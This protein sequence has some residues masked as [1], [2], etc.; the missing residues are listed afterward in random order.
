MAASSQDYDLLFWVVCCSIFICCR[1]SQGRV[2]PG[3]RKKGCH[4]LIS[5]KEKSNI[6]KVRKISELQIRFEI[7]NY[8]KSD[9]LTSDLLEV[10]LGAGSKFIYIYTY[11]RV[12][13]VTWALVFLSSFFLCNW[14]IL[15]AALTS[16][17]CR[18]STSCCSSLTL[19]VRDFASSS[20][21]LCCYKRKAIH[22][23]WPCYH[24]NVKMYSISWTVYQ[25]YNNG[26]LSGS[27]ND[28]FLLHC[29]V[30]SCSGTSMCDH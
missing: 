10:L 27:W 19:S 14:S 7:R 4:T 13:M 16:S 21:R 2:Q 3:D 20:F 12:L 30:H 9:D 29:V 28:M 26:F 22:Y 24:Y 11:L 17:P 5:W 15:S 18:Y 25:G 23:L 8:S 6:G 1:N